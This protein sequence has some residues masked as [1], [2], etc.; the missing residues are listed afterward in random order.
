[1]AEGNWHES[2]N[3]KLVKCTA[4]IKC[5]LGGTHY[6][7]ATAKEAETNREKQLLEANELTTPITKDE[8]IPSGT[9]FIS[10]CLNCGQR[11]NVCTCADN[12]HDAPRAPQAP[13]N[14]NHEKT[15]DKN[16]PKGETILS[17]AD[18]SRGGLDLILKDIVEANAD[19][20]PGSRVIVRVVSNKGRYVHQSGDGKHAHNLDKVNEDLSRGINEEQ[21]GASEHDTKPDG[22]YVF[23]LTLFSQD[24]DFTVAD[25]GKAT[26]QMLGKDFDGENMGIIVGSVNEEDLE[27][28]GNTLY[29]ISNL[30]EVRGRNF[31]EMFDGNL[32]QSYGF[33]EDAPCYC[34]DGDEG[35]HE[36]D[37]GEIVNLETGGD[38]EFVWKQGARM[39]EVYAYRG[40]GV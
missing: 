9:I 14:P 21:S 30:D 33:D 2:S 6:E 29:E 24:Q 15:A 31:E 32:Q 12:A 34:E 1:M 10:R 22:V 37:C 23:D 11:Q 8:S 13:E 26:S 19:K 39:N 5:R 18:D 25:I 17:Y 7:G 36:D 16:N 27:S 38:K 3:G 40:M 28:V 20:Y 35:F 4:K